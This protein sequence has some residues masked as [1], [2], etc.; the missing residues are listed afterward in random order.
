MSDS[1]KKALLAREIAYQ[2]KAS[3][4]ILLDMRKVTAFTDYFLICNGESDTQVRAIAE[5]ITSE[6]KKRKVKVWHV[7][8][9]EEAKWTLLD[10]GSVV[11]HIFQPEVRQ[12]YQLEKLW[13]DAPRLG[14][15][16]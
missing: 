15:K 10:Y 9:Y 8:G 7:A 3:D 4:M 12:F 16:G 1:K 2:K 13:A 5:T 6:M 11:I 14:L